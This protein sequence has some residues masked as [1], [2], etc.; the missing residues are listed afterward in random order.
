MLAPDPQ[1][2]VATARFRPVEDFANLTVLSLQFPA[3]RWSDGA[4][5]D[6]ERRRLVKEFLAGP[7]AGQFENPIQWFYDPM[8]VP[9]FVGEMGE[10]LTVYDC[11]DELSKFAG[12]PPQILERER[13]LLARADLVFTGGH[14]L[15]Q[16][17]SRSNPNCHFFGC[18]VDVEHFSQARVAATKVPDELQQLPKPLF[19]YFGV[20]D[21]RLDYE[22][23]AN[24]A[25]ANSTG[26]IVMIGPVL[27]VDQRQ[28]PQRPNLHWL[29]PRPYAALPG[30]CK[31]FDVCL[32]PF[33][34]NEA[35]EYINPTKA[36]EYMA[37][38]REIVS[39]AVADVIH[40]FGSV[41]KVAASRQEFVD[42]CLRA[43]KAPDAPAI[44]RGLEMV[45]HNSWDAIVEKLEEHLET[46]LDRKRSGTGQE[47][48]GTEAIADVGDRL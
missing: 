2:A 11:M 31:A 28:L 25:D 7:G 5:V 41:V 44:S 22:L 12:A 14:K 3:W 4:Y 45:R 24:L 42:Q 47:R 39:T 20:I 21:E 29:G 36:L 13:Q 38:G 35:T 46:V 1:L 9:A 34:L 48:T 43:A 26:S 16:L 23:L 6:A 17:K 37:T 32:M 10:V 30:F 18:G 40:N 33:A 8:A 19:G 27:K 15:F